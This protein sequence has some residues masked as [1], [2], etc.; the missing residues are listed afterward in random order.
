MKFWK[1]IK[2]IKILLSSQSG[3]SLLKK[4]H[5]KKIS[6][7]TCPKWQLQ[8][9]LISGAD[10]GI[11]VSG[12]ALDRRGVWGLKMLKLHLKVCR[13]MLKRHYKCFSKLFPSFWTFRFLLSSFLPSSPLSL[14]LFFFFFFLGGG[15]RTG[16]APAWIRACI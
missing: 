3:E 7:T 1:K 6:Q 8:T 12:G 2:W 5:C 11:Y 14:S 13:K 4:H 15:G 10:P 16:S 9:I